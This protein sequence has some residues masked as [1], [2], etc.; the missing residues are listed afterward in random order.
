MSGVLAVSCAVYLGALE[1]IAE[2]ASGW[3]KLWKAIGVV[4]LIAGAAELI[5]AA[6]G[7]GDLLQPLRGVGGSAAGGVSGAKPADLFRK[8]KSV[9]DVERE[10]A[11]AKA[12]GKP[13]LL[14]F[15][16]DWCVS[17]KEMEKFTFAKS[18][19]QAAL[20]GFVALQADVTEQDD[21]DKELMKRYS[22]VAPPDTLFFGRDG[23]E[24]HELQLT[25][26]EDADKFLK[27]L[28]AAAAK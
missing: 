8:I 3:S 23:A 28:A 7:S 26:P 2:G 20:A 21:A 25:G 27:R 12:A 1:R 4:L 24:K 9:V 16:A 18:D 5:G 17:C 11:A 6:A 19:V 10:L 15:Y 22:I 13:V 14:D